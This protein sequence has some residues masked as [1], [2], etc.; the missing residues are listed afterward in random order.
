MAI[1][2]GMTL[3]TLLPLDVQP[4]DIPGRL[5]LY[6]VIWRPRVLRV[7][8]SSLG[9]AKGMESQ[10]FMKEHMMFLSSHDAV[11]HAKQVLFK[12]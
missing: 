9:I 11:E 2:N 6:E 1:K 5:K 8:E 3:S 12:Y 10:E 4:E 7:G